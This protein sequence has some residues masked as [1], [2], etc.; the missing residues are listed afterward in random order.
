MGRSAVQQLKAVL[1]L[2]LAWSRRL[3]LTHPL[4][5][6]RTLWRW[7]S[8]RTENR[9]PGGKRGGNE[10]VTTPSPSG[11]IVRIDGIAGVIHASDEPAV[12]PA[13]RNRRSRSPSPLSL[14]VA[15]S[16]HPHILSPVSENSESPYSF[17]VE[18]PSEAS[19]ASSRFSYAGSEHLSVSMSRSA[20]PTRVPRRLIDDRLSRIIT[21]SSSRRNRSQS[22][23]RNRTPAGSTTSLSRTLQHGLSSKASFAS[24]KANVAAPAHQRGRTPQ[25]CQKTCPILETRRYDRPEKL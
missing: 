7:F 25:R 21:A 19:I 22:S 5:L 3:S 6:L 9:P 20:S 23:S 8:M 10:D 12:F 17:R 24:S 2:L 18:N 11:D 16:S 4:S 14:N 13:L 15:T 1:R